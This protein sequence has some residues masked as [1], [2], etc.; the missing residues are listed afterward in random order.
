[1]NLSTFTMASN[2]KRDLEKFADSAGRFSSTASWLK[3]ALWLMV[4]LILALGVALWAAPASW[5]DGII[6]QA[7]EGRLRMTDTQGGLWN[8]SGRLVLANIDTPESVRGQV[9]NDSLVSGVQIPGRCNW[10]LNPWPLFLAQLDI[11]LKLEH[12]KDTVRISG[13]RQKLVGSAGSFDLP[14]I[15]MDRLG[16]PWNTI[17]PS[18]ALS[19]RWESFQVEQGKFVGKAAVTVAQAASALSNVRPLG[20]YRIDIDS[21]GQKAQISI[22]TINGP[23]QL[24]GRGDWTLRGGLKFLAYAQATA[25]QLKLQPLLSLLGKRDG[26]KTIIRLG[27]V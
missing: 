10:Q 2:S 8:G 18:G 21:N 16:S 23:L 12:M 5:L 14:Q 13:N 17:Q 11:R 26:D 24:D 3:R 7:S 20:S 25:E 19:V 9:S 6:R 22:V 27:A 4:V 1:M 15:R